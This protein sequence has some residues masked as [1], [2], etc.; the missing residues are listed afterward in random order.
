MYDN[1]KR[2]NVSEHTTK[3]A[4]LEFFKGATRGLREG[5]MAGRKLSEVILCCSYFGTFF[6]TWSVFIVSQSSLNMS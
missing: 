5:W 4:S 1:Q 6:S 2:V 3:M